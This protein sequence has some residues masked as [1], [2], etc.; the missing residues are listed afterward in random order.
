M[1]TY[2]HLQLGIEE[3]LDK[4]PEMTKSNAFHGLIALAL[5]SFGFFGSLSH[6]FTFGLVVLITFNALLDYKNFKTDF[7][8]I[9]LYL[10]LTSFFYLF[11]CRSLFSHNA[12]QVL[13]SL[14]P[15]LAIPILGILITITKDKEFEISSSTL[16][17][18]S[19]LAI[20]ITFSIYLFLMCFPDIYRNAAIGNGARLELLSG[21]PIPFSIVALG[22]SL[23]SLTSWRKDSQKEKF[24]SVFCLFIGLYLALYLANSRGTILAFILSMPVI[25]WFIFRS[26]KS[27]IILF[28]VGIATIYLF[29]ELQISGVID[30]D[31]IYRIIKGVKTLATGELI[32]NSSYVRTKLWS[33]AL[34]VISKDPILGFGLPERFSALLPILGANF[35]YNFSHPHNDILASAISAGLL[36][37]LLSITSITSPMWA[38]ILIKRKSPE[39]MYLGVSLSIIF[40][41]SAN[42]NTIYFNDI[43]AAWLAFSTFLISRI[44]EN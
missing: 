44:S 41:T 35:S 34:V 26:L 38:W 27:L 40:L 33:A 23:M 19:R 24:Q 6:I 36:G 22:L 28:I 10:L 43:T 12:H 21:N 20:I 15:M 17:K 37:G 16:A 13:H 14:S 18:F 11:L 42:F 39:V 2:S 30:S 7:S 3:L 1:K 4:E 8:K 5:I 32:D 29:F 31:H 25:F 9:L